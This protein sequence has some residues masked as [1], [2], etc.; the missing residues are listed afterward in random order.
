MPAVRYRPS[1]GSC[2]PAYDGAFTCT[3]VNRFWYSSAIVVSPRSGQL[4]NGVGSAP[5]GQVQPPVP[6]LG[7][8]AGP[9]RTA[10]NHADGAPEAG[11]ES[12]EQAEP[13]DAE[14]AD[15]IADRVAKE[16]VL[17]LGGLDRVAPAGVGRR[18][19]QAAVQRKRQ[20]GG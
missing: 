7:P 18:E 9:E 2:S 14:R 13:V 20:H 4:V 15:R 10:E 3:V 5:H 8:A 6:P 17:V 11:G 12:Q 19:D 1:R 16:G